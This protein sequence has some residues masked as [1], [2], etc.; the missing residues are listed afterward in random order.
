ML[1]LLLTTIDENKK[2]SSHDTTLKDLPQATIIS[3]I[4]SHLREEGIKTLDKEE[5]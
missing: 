1:K 2:P 4:A 5:I 3:M